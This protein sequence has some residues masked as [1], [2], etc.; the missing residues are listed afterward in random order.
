[1]DYMRSGYLI[2]TCCR[3]LT[4]ATLSLF[5]FNLLPIPYLDGSELLESFVD[6]AFHTQRDAFTYDV[7]ALESNERDYEGF[8][9]RRRWKALIVRC[10]H[11]VTT[12]LVA[13]Y[14]LITLLNSMIS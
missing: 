5:F 8:R 11:V 9:R 1:V 3:Y 14:I 4:M 6:L 12:A 10:F 13:S 2:R 7:E